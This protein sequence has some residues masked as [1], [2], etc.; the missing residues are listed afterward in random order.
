MELLAIPVITLIGTIFLTINKLSNLFGD[1]FSQTATSF[2]L[3]AITENISAEVHDV[4]N[5]FDFLTKES[6][7]TSR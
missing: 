6:T 7:A 4:I 2:P 3:T 5:Y 1:P